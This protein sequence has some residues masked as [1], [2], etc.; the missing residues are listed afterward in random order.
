MDH[1]TDPAP[2]PAA[3]GAPSS[4]RTLREALAGVP[5]LDDDFEADIAAATALL[6]EGDPPYPT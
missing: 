3:S 6:T 4:G 2:D 5:P 1:P